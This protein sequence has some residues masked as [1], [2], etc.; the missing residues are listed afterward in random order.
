[1]SKVQPKLTQDQILHNGLFDL[2]LR[3]L[4]MVQHS[5]KVVSSMQRVLSLFCLLPKYFCLLQELPPAKV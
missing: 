2:G 4:H 1:M 5:A 3:G